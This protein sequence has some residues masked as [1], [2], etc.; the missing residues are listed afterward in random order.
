ME[1]A[2]KPHKNIGALA[3]FSFPIFPQSKKGVPYRHALRRICKR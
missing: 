1:K 2:R 3:G